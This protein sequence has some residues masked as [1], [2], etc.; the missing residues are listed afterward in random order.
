VLEHYMTGGEVVKQDWGEIWR[1]VSGVTPAE[2]DELRARLHS[3]Y[4]RL[5]ITLRAIEDWSAE[6]VIGDG[7]AL[8]VHTAYHLGEIRQALCTVGRSEQAGI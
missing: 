2:W 3:T 6:D 4:G 8:V 5:S 1:R 7:I